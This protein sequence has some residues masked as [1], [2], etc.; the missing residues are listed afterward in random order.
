MAKQLGFMVIDLEHQ[1]IGAVD[2]DRMMEVR[3][4]MWFTDLAIGDGPTLR[5]RDRL[6][7]AERKGEKPQ[8][9]AQDHKPDGPGKESDIAHRI[10][11]P[12]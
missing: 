4:G 8:E 6:G 7:P 12:G 1:F 5:V 3:D 2:E 10:H 11:H 9:C